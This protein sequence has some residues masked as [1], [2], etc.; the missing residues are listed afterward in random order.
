MTTGFASL[1]SPT[2]QDGHFQSLAQVACDVDTDAG[3][4][5]ARTPPQQREDLDGRET[6]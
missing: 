6:L 5:K 3:F 1:A 2:V 4:R